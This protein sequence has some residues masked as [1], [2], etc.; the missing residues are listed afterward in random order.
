MS[1]S[2]RRIT[3]EVS[4][5]QFGW[6]RSGRRRPGAPIA[7]VPDRLVEPEPAPTAQSDWR[8]LQLPSVERERA[9]AIERQAFADGYAE[10]QRRAEAEADS[11]LADVRARL[12]QAI[13]DVGALRPA[14]VAR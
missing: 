3:G 11:E 6:Q 13:G 12:G 8:E 1:R 14:L 4:T 7:L 5:E 9:L 10:G 2:A